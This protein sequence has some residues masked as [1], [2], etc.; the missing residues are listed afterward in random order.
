MR[1][2]KCGYENKDDA[3]WCGL[4]GEILRRELPKEPAELHRPPL[5]KEAK[6]TPLLQTVGFGR[7]LAAYFLDGVV[8]MLFGGILLIF[9]VR[10]LSNLLAH[11]ITAVYFIGMWVAFD[12]ATVG[13]KIMKIKIVTT[14][15]QSLTIGRAFLRYIGYFL[16]G[17]LFGL[18]YLWIIW[19]KQN[20][21]WHDKITGTIVIQS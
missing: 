10:E 4:C 5:P 6:P 8:L 20:Q 3:V 7:R 15:G 16:S 14:D 11:L 17:I 19:D 18:G 12:G 9:G 2:P 1:C 13:K 21:G